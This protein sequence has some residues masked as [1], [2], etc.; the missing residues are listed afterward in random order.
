M[1]ALLGA[2]GR[3]FDG[4]VDPA[5]TPTEV[6]RSPQATHIRYRVERWA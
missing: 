1:T 2:G 6:I 3:V 5:F 4:V